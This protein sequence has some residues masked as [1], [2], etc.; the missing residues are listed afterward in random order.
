MAKLK[1][2]SLINTGIACPTQWEGQLEDGRFIYIRYRWG[3]LGFGIGKDINEAID[4]YTHGEDI[5]GLS[6]G[7]LSTNEMIKNLSRRLDFR[8][9]IPSSINS[10]DNIYG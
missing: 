7:Y 9:D 1:F 6:D 10:E 2:K 3:N 4:N 5:G 8:N